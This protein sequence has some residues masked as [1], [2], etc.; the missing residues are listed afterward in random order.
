MLT[1]SPTPRPRTIDDLLGRDLIARIDRLDLLS[2]KVFAGKLPGERR[3]KKRGQSVEFDDYRAYTPGDDL[4]HI[5]WNVYARLDRL[6]LKLFREEEDLGLHLVIDASASMDAGTPSKLVF[7][8][9][10]AMALGYIGLVNQNRVTASV[11]G[12]GPVRTLAP[13]RGRRS[14]ARLAEF[15]LS[16]NDPDA[17]AGE[18]AR[19]ASEGTEPGAQ[20]TG[21]MPIEEPPRSGGV[22]QTP[23][24]SGG[25]PQTPPRSGGVPEGLRAVAS[26]R[27]GRGV[28]VVMSDFLVREN[29][30]TALNYLSGGGHDVYLL[31]VLSP[32]E[33]DPSKEEV[34]GDL[35]L[36]D[37]ETGQAS[38]VTVSAALVK[39][40]RQRLAALT[41][42]LR[43][44]A[45]ARGMAHA[46]VPSDTDLSALL[47]DYLRTRGL[48]G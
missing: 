33:I 27:R 6:I 37:I 14:V 30:R 7:A 9:R 19:R 36:S 31:Q 41:E 45:A 21:E 47:L 35:R 18:R 40:Y 26:A 2:R 11:I 42:S 12:A 46:V 39:R 15:V 43:I 32:G 44:A 5:D 16:I 3:S 1:P 38:E 22:P 4:R 24:R 10:L 28:M 48:V 17:Q 29:L 20:A 23:P 34:V 8:Q 25:P 13:M